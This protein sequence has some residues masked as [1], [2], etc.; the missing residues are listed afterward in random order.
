MV[1]SVGKQEVSCVQDVLHVQ[2]RVELPS[3]IVDEQWSILLVTPVAVNL[4]LV[5]KWEE[6]FI[7]AKERSLGVKHPVFVLEHEVVGFLVVP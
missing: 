4:T 5:K 7:P 6:F 1:Q 3:E 2:A